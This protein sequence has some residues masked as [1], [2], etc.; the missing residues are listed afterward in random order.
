MLINRSQQRLQLLDSKFNLKKFKLD[1]ER[2]QKVTSQ[3]QQELVKVLKN[4]IS[5]RQQNLAN[6]LENLNT[7]SP[8]NTMLRGYTIVNKEQQV[9]TST[10]DLSE[11]DSI[12]LTMKDGTVDAKVQKVRCEDDE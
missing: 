6:K 1:I 12:V 3:K 9:I 8:T 5:L 4:S 11:N 2:Y 10:K 7:L